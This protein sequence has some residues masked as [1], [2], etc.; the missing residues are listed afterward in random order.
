MRP[1]RLD[2]VGASSKQWERWNRVCD[3]W[4]FTHRWLGGAWGPYR[5]MTAGEVNQFCLDV[6]QYGSHCTIA[7][8]AC[9]VERDGRLTPYATKFP[10]QAAVLRTWLARGTIEIANHGLTH[11]QEGDH[12]PG[13]HGNRPRHREF[14]PWLTAEDAYERLQRAQAGLRLAFGVAPEVFVPPGHMFPSEWYGVLKAL[15]LRLPRPG[16]LAW[17]DRAIVVEGFDPG[18]VLATEQFTCA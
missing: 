7:V 10:D 4:P 14:G 18:G 12:V 13:W 6:S 11:C 1:L 9:W 2:D 17:H 5:E 8:T 16:G 15:D 3:I